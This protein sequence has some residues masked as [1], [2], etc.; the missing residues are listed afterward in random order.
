MSPREGMRNGALASLSG[1][2]GSGVAVVWS[3]MQRRE[4]QNSEAEKTPAEERLR[5]AGSSPA[6]I[7]SSRKSPSEAVPV[8]SPAKPVNLRAGKY[9]SAANLQEGRGKEKIRKIN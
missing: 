7:A 5:F 8:L 9:L 4:H 6:E 2:K 3:L 1:K